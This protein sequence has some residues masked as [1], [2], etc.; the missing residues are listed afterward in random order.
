VLLAQAIM[1]CG[2]ESSL[3]TLEISVNLLQF[4]IFLFEH[5]LG[6]K[7]EEDDGQEGE[8]KTEWASGTGMGEGDGA[9]DV[10]DQIEDDSQLEGTKNEEQGAEKEP[11]EM[12]QDQKEDNAREV[13]FNLETEAQ[14]VPEK[15]DG[16]EDKDQ[17]K[18]G[19]DELDREKGDVD[20]NNGGKL[21]DKMWNGDEEEDDKKDDGEDDP[22]NEKEKE[23]KQQEEIEAHGAQ[24]EGEADQ[25]AADDTKKDNKRKPE[26]KPG[27]D[28]NSQKEDDGKEEEQQEKDKEDAGDREEG[29]AQA[30]EYDPEKDGQFDVNLKGNQMGED[31]E[32]GEQGEGP[33][34]EKDGEM[35]ENSDMDLDGNDDDEDRNSN[36]GE[37]EN[38]QEEP[39]TGMD[40]DIEESCAPAMPPELPEE[41]GTADHKPEVVQGG[42]DPDKDKEDNA[43]EKG[44]DSE[45]KDG[46]DQ[47]SRAD[48]VPTEGAG[49]EPQEQPKTEGEAAPEAGTENQAPKP[50][51]EEKL[52]GG[53]TGAS[54]TF[55]E[56]AQDQKEQETGQ[57]KS[58]G[59][60][61]GAM[62]DA[63]DPNAS[64]AEK[65]SQ[66]P[67]KGG[68]GG[69]MAPP[70]Q[71]DDVG[72]ENPEERK[73]QKVVLLRGDDGG[74]NDPAASEEKKTGAEQGLHIA[75]PTEG[76]EAL[77]ETTD[78]AANQQQAMGVQED[79]KADQDESERAAMEEDEEKDPNAKESSQAFDQ[80]RMQ[81]VD[82]ENAVGEM[83]PKVPDADGDSDVE[84]GNAEAL[85]GS[86]SLVQASMSELQNLRIEVPDVEMAAAAAS[87]SSTEVVQRRKRSPDEVRSLWSELERTT[88]PLASMLCEQLRTILEPTMKGRLQGYYRT[89]KRIAMRRVIPFIASNYRRDKIWLRRTKPSKREYQIVV[90]IDNSRSMKECQVAPMALQTLCTVCQALAQLEVGEYAVMAFGGAQPQVLLPLGSGQPH[91]A[92]FNYEQ[93][94]PLLTEFTFEEESV[95]SHNQSFADMMKLSSS[96][97]DERSGSG[98]TRPFGQVMLIISDGR[99][100]KAKVRP[101][102]QTAIARQQLPL[103]V[104]VDSTAEAAAAVGPSG[105]G[106]AAPSK[107]S[108]SRSVF[109]VKQVSYEGGKC[110]VT[111]YLQDFP[112]PYYV[113]VQD[114]QAL[115]SILS[116]VLKQW[117][118]LMANA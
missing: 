97:F 1:L 45:K 96:M 64:N 67:D 98:P 4:I 38:E 18:P 28:Q 22:Q 94:A 80:M 73:L 63:N 17:E 108:K 88:S 10:T 48:P 77:A 104:I 58:S 24:G 6:S 74:D 27:D 68:V 92:M 113:V 50:A 72:P 105:G 39:P 25:T 13:G 115:P 47:D 95:E 42:E 111:P 11:P 118:E 37:D 9:K 57:D 65:Q 3:G 49:D 40:L 55:E 56:Q 103:L 89:G 29:E 60:E 20:L 99:F 66:K 15:E 52:F 44:E 23:Q 70:T 116:D 117:F 106:S 34:E 8:G 79:E 87:S 43:E 101:W 85:R 112:F 100:N 26:E 19:E 102:V 5:G 59:M 16:E 91:T 30:T 75:D 76:M 86:Q 61:Q 54:T 14:A 84:M 110:T 83:K 62:T 51:A 107:S 2:L 82:P 33:E 12:P 71:P 69:K 78:P 32:Q 46:E 53:S 81:E 93:A 90:A 35:G 21:D 36:A 7:S 109:D 31:D 41:D 114:L